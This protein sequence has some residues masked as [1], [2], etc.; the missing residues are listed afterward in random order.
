M[1][2]IYQIEHTNDWKCLNDE[3][4]QQKRYATWLQF[5]MMATNTNSKTLRQEWWLKPWQKVLVISNQ[6]ATD[7]DSKYPCSDT[8]IGMAI[9]WMMKNDNKRDMKFDEGDHCCAPIAWKHI[10]T[11]ASIRNMTVADDGHQHQF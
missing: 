3:G 7:N 1:V 6:I 5:P 8:G 9:A 10:E 2:I 11:C 4:R